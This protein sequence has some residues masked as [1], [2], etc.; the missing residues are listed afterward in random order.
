VGTARRAPNAAARAPASAVV[1]SD[2]PGWRGRAGI[3]RAPGHHDAGCH[4][5][6][7]YGYR[8]PSGW[9]PVNTVCLVVDASGCI[10]R[11]LPVPPH[12]LRKVVG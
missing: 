1:H 12:P 6:L 7:G 9:H 4:Y 11:G 10:S 3:G 2:W 8:F 5:H